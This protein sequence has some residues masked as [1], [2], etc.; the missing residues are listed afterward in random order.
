MANRYQRQRKGIILLAIISLLT[1]FMIFG[2]TYVVSL[3]KRLGL[4]VS[5]PTLN[6]YLDRNL[7][8]PAFKQAVEKAVE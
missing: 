4:L 1:M 7:A 5:Y 6:S 2:V 8:R 3:A